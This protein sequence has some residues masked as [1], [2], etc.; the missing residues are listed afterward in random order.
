MARE[1]RM[2][3][4]EEELLQTKRAALT[5]IMSMADAIANTPEGRAE[6]ARGF[7]AAAEHPEADAAMVRLPK[8]VAAALRGERRH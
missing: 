8:R 1:D 4:L 3:V 2:S 5:M 7:E 6:L